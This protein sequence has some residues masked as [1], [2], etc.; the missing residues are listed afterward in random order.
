MQADQSSG[1]QRVGVLTLAG[2]FGLSVLGGEKWTLEADDELTVKDFKELLAAR[3]AIPADQ[4]RLI[5]KGYVLKDTRTLE[6]YA[7]AAGHTV[8]LVK[9]SKKADDAPA[10]D[11]SA[12][13][14]VAAASAA[15]PAATPA[16]APAA[17]APA[18]GT[19]SANPW[20]M[21][22]GAQGGAAP[23]STPA[24]GGA[25]NPFAAMMGGMG[26]MGGMDF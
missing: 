15:A 6:S 9:G 3:C 1:G 14:P 19:P 25:A 22:G 11:G 4:Q 23:A 24:T 12:S 8:L 10:A 13:A 17:A 20:N 18:T 2:V 16:A 26:G 5:Y 7:I 21:F